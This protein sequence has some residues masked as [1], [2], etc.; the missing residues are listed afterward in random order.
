MIAIY[1]FQYV[2]KTSVVLKLLCN[3]QPIML[4][5]WLIQLAFVRKCISNCF[6]SLVCY[7]SYNCWTHTIVLS[8][9]N[10]HITSDVESF[11]LSLSLSLR[12]IGSLLHT[13]ICKKSSSCSCKCF[14]SF[15]KQIFQN[16]CCLTQLQ[17]NPK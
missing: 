9:C 4:E 10:L 12:I 8:Y 5:L 13:K 16:K 11:S 2:R 6:K 7:Y 17:K 15:Y 14:T 3:C 1:Y